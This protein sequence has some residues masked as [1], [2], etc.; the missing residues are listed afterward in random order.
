VTSTDP[1][2]IAERLGVPVALVCDL[3]RRGH[4]Q[5]LDL[6]PA[7]LRLRLWRAYLGWGE[8]G[9]ETRRSSRR[10]HSSL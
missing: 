4:L 7:E 10:R 8:S 6:D 1:R 5:R 2:A 9:H 3:Q